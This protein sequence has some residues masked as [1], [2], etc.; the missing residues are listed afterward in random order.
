MLNGKV[1]GEIGFLLVGILLIQGLSACGQPKEEPTAA[2]PTE[3]PT[4]VPPS[5][6]PPV[7]ETVTA[8]VTE[9]VPVVTE[10]TEEPL[11]MV[12]GTD[13]CEA[14]LDA[15]MP[16]YPGGDLDWTLG[17]QPGRFIFTGQAEDINDVITATNLT[18]GTNLA[19]V[20]ESGRQEVDLTNLLATAGIVFGDGSGTPVIRLYEDNQSPGQT[21]DTLQV[22]YET[23]TSGNYQ[24]F[25][26]LNYLVASPWD[27]EGSPWDVEG[28]PWDVEGSQSD[29][30]FVSETPD[31]FG[32]ELD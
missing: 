12:S 20:V 4:E 11:Q 29:D 3:T 24:V 21:I 26:D 18:A 9:P 25:A 27:V 19:L 2:V 14:L 28:S 32:N 23:V 13:L 7:A 10:V 1:R 6:M 16:G 22:I 31:V 8:A 17:F 30:F 5:K 15:P